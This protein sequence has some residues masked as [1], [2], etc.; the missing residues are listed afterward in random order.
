MTDTSS[1]RS[2]VQLINF[3]LCYFRSYPI[4]YS[5]SFMEAE[6]SLPGSQR[7]ANGPHPESVN[8]RLHSHASM[9]A[10]PPAHLILLNLIALIILGRVQIMSA[11]IMQFF[12]FSYYLLILR[13]N[14]SNVLKTDSAQGLYAHS[15][16]VFSD[17]THPC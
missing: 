12:L 4:R 10:T 7:S 15:V 6:D 17:L 9:R 1:N 3:I 13:S 11:R 5:S 2:G 8:F 14:K 16:Y